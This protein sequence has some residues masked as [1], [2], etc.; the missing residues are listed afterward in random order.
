[1]NLNKKF[2]TIGVVLL[3]FSWVGNIFFYEKHILSEPIFI[4]HYYDVPDGMNNIQLYYIQ[5]I[6]SQESIASIE[7]PEIGQDFISFTESDRN[8]DNHY[9]KLK[10]ISVNLYNRDQNK[11]P[12]NLKN[13]VITKAKFTFTNGKVLDEDIGKVYLYSNNTND[14]TLTTVKASS[15]S[16]NMGAST[17]RASKDIKITGIQ[18][19]FPEI[20]GDVVSMKINEKAI[21]D[22]K[23]PLELKTG[24]TVEVSYGFK[25]NKDD[26][27]R[28]NAYNFTIDILTE[29]TDGTK[30]SRL[31]MLNYWLQFPE[32][33]DI[34]SLRMDRR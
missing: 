20:V 31:C 12:D 14:P 8:S 2:I 3:I 10:S 27:R 16:D 9:Y 26:I 4:K 19:K 25:F 30:G 29:N 15:S 23:L 1:M 18:T 32:Q 22:I 11:V 7:F 34:Q 28:N 17:L 6:N 21:K 5:N 24:D 33:Y 13:K